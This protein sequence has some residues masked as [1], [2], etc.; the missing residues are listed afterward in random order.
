MT[1]KSPFL[2]TVT[3]ITMKYLRSLKYIGIFLF[4][5]SSCNDH[6]A[7]E[8]LKKSSS[9]TELID[10]SVQ[11]LDAIRAKKPSEIKKANQKI[12]RY[13]IENIS[14]SLKDDVQKKTFWINF[15]N[16]QVQMALEEDST[17]YQD[18]DH[19]FSKKFIPIGDK[20]ISLDQIEHGILRKSNFKYGL[21]FIQNPFVDNFIKNQSVSKLDYR[22]HF[23][24]NCG[25]KSCPPIQI[26]EAEHFHDQITGNAGFFLKQVS[27]YKPM[28]NNVQTTP[29]FQWFLGDFNGKKGVLKILE[30]LEIIPENSKGIAIEYQPYDW[31]LKL[32]YFATT[33]YSTP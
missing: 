17:L 26:Y 29:L 15:Y 13:S 6:H 32:A 19:F 12:A 5:F 23:A 11:L 4:L 18:R 2:K 9:S 7:I 8:S 10:Y 30:N 21:G 28:E 27:Y 1:L 22:I 33:D 14:Q 31:T 24:L 20:K 25:A 3:T 16:A